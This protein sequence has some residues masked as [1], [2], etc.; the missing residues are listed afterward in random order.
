MEN[1]DLFF[2][3]PRHM[4]TGKRLAGFPRDEIIPAIVVFGLCFWQGYSI[5]GIILGL[6]WFGGIRFLKVGYGEHIVALTF[7]WWTEG[8]LSQAYFTRTPSSERRYWI[9]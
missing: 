8:L 6:G 2:S 5:L 9:F 7:Y 4:N 3:I 1:P